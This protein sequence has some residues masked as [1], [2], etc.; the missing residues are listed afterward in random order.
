MRHLSPF[1]D[2]SHIEQRDITIRNTIFQHPYPVRQ[3]YITITQTALLVLEDDTSSFT[4]ATYYKNIPYRICAWSSEDS[5][6]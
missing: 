3:C 1:D 2:S 5:F 4:G 6:A